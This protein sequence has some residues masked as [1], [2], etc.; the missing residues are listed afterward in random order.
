M[1]FPIAFALTLVT[2]EVLLVTMILWRC[3]WRRNDP[4]PFDE[5]E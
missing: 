1:I 4:W 5:E 3:W 2:V